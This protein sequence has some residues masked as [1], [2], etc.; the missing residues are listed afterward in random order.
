MQGHQARWK[1]DDCRSVGLEQKRRCG[2]IEGSRDQSSSVVWVSSIGIEGEPRVS[3]EECP[4]SYVS[5]ES[6]AWVEDFLAHRALCR[7]ADTGEWPARR[8]D[9]FVLLSGE[10]RKWE[11]QRRAE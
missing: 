1:C 7:G 11:N 6:A 3:L 4:V 10:L 2:W 9:A 8:V 5:G